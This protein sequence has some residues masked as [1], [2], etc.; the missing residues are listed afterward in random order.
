MRVACVLVTH[1]RAKVEMCRHPHLEDSPVLIVDR[2]P[3]RA[4]PVVVDRFQS[5]SGVVAGMTLE[6]AVSRH[7]NAVVLD[8]DQPHYRRVFGQVLASLQG[9][10]DRVRGPSWARPT[11]DWTVSK[12]C[13]GARLG[14][15]RPC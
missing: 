2:D 8:A 4:R 15:S 11:C 10:S 13:T 3:S 12:G 5:A 6:Q 14:S 9:I 1:L 7:A